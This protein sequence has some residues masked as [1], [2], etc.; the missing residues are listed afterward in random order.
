MESGADCSE[1]EFSDGYEDAADALVANAQYF[2]AV[3]EVSIN[4]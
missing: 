4:A 3:L 1:D 2:L